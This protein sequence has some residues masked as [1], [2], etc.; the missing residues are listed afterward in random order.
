M[1]KILHITTKYLRGSIIDE[2][3]KIQFINDKTGNFI[4]S[5]YTTVDLSPLLNVKDGLTFNNTLDTDTINLVSNY[6]SLLNLLNNDF[7]IEFW[8]KINGTFGYSVLLSRVYSNSLSYAIIYIEKLTG[9]TSDSLTLALSSDGLTWDQTIVVENAS[10]YLTK[11]DNQIA[12]FRNEDTINITINGILRKQQ[13][14][15]V[16]YTINSNTDG[17]QL[18][19]YDIDEYAVT[20]GIT[21]PSGKILDST[22]TLPGGS[23]PVNGDAFPDYATYSVLI[24]V[25][26]YESEKEQIIWMGYLLKGALYK[27]NITTN[28]GIFFNHISTG[29]G[30]SHQVNGDPIP[31]LR[32][33]SIAYNPVTNKLYAGH[34]GPIWEYD[35]YTNTGYIIPGSDFGNADWRELNFDTD[36][37]RLYGGRYNTGIPKYIDLDVDYTVHDLTVS[38]G[39]NF[40]ASHSNQAVLNPNKTKL[41]TTSAGISPDWAWL[42]DIPTETGKLLNAA[43]TGPGGSYEVTG[44]AAPA[45]DAEKAI[46]YI[47]D[48]GNY[49][50]VIGYWGSGV[51]FYD[52]INNSAKLFNT[53]STDNGGD[54]EVIGDPL[55]HNTIYNMTVIDN[56]L[57]I[58]SP[59]GMWEYN[60]LTNIAK[61]YTIA[62]TGSGGNYEVTGESLT[63]NTT[64][65]SYTS[66]VAKFGNTYYHPIEGTN[67]IWIKKDYSASYMNGY[68]NDLII[69]NENPPYNG[70]GV[71]EGHDVFI[72]NRT[73]NVSSQK[74]I[75]DLNANDGLIYSSGTDIEKW[76]GNNSKIYCE[77]SNVSYQ[78]I[79]NSTENAIQFTKTNSEFLSLNKVF[80]YSLSFTISFWYRLTDITSN[81]ILLSQRDYP[82]SSTDYLNIY[83]ILLEN[84]P[85]L[86]LMFNNLEGTNRL[87]TSILYTANTWHHFLA[88]FDGSTSSSYGDGKPRY[89]QSDITV[90][91]IGNVVATL[92]KI[93]NYGSNILDGMI[94]DIKI[95]REV[96]ETLVNWTGTALKYIAGTEV[97]NPVPR[98]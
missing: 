43:N 60:P 16:D 41:A 49:I 32:V 39:D 79:Y 71:S 95:I 89:V 31:D 69:H 7:H 63:T 5:S 37:N 45:N 34:R 40:T 74:S 97:F 54:Y 46:W 51:W 8:V 90:T 30:G 91:S 42:Y 15:S 48:L 24:P 98:T 36:I 29:I 96:D 55:P 47:D 25:I 66:F 67:G 44:D 73:G 13:D 17:L 9:W 1:S 20:S 92:G 81:H 75:L 65:D 78:P 3:N 83:C 4:F 21:Y 77:Q 12:V 38:A 93:Q 50:L 57:F 6:D 87:N 70:I 86:R 59:G 35:F 22:S 28:T 61:N 68:I 72:P 80:N 53:T 33:K 27:Y 64:R 23:Y 52:E 2:N 11:K 82:T 58:G 26:Q 56:I 76:M 19:A 62:S 94:D 14:L 18:A 84:T 85:I 10:N 88:T